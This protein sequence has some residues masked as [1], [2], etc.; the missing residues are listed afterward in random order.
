MVRLLSIDVGIRNLA[1]CL[2]DDSKRIFEWE[3]GGVPPKHT[4]G[5]FAALNK[6]LDDRPW[7]LTS[8]HVIIERQP[9]KNKL[10]KSVEHFLHAYFIIHKRDVV[11]WHAKNKVPDV[12]GPGKRKYAK[13]KAVSV[14]R[15]EALIQ[16]QS[17]MLTFFKGHKK[18]DDLADSFMQGVSYFG[19]Y[20]PAAPKVRC[21][22]R[23]PTEHQKAHKYSRANLA[24]L[25]KNG[26]WK[27]DA[28]WHKDLT[29]YYSSMDELIAD[30]FSTESK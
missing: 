28:R 22:A 17:D 1:M 2:M 13:R 23:R 19:A 4:D 10:I 29:D 9:D 21:V 15:C 20:V 5:L 6:Y 8:D 26:D 25:Y 24:W 3:V 11:L 30:F 12:V 27:N 18:K 7:V 14:E 16:G